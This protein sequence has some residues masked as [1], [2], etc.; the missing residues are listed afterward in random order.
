MATQFSESIPFKEDWGTAA[1]VT[2]IALVSL[3]PEQIMGL[4]PIRKESDFCVPDPCNLICAVEGDLTRFLFKWP[5]NTLDDDYRL[6]KWDGLSWNEIVT[7]NPNNTLGAQ[8]GTKF[9]FGTLN[10][11]NKYSGYELDWGDIFTNHEAGIY[12]FVV[13]NA[14]PADKQYSLPFELKKDT[15]DNKNNTVLIEIDSTGTFSNLL[16]TNSNR[17]IKEFDLSNDNWT[18]SIRYSGR[19]MSQTPGV[20]KQIIHFDDLSRERQITDI[21]IN[22]NLIIYKTLYETYLRLLSYGLD[23]DNIKIS[24]FSDDSEFSFDQID[25]ISKGEV[26]NVEKFVNNKSLFGVTIA[27]QNAHTL[28]NRK[29]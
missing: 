23:S 13:F 9:T 21:E 17:G 27:M 6:E 2:S 16:F 12:R 18:D 1:K 11:S 5:S 7:G 19:M 14:T 10:T 4:S 8:D 26:S 3:L 22:Y 20:E 25:I 29:C 28:R 15:C 24:D